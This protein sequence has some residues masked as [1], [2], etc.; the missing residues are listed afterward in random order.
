MTMENEMDV[1]AGW[2][3]DGTGT[4]TTR[5]WDGGKWT[6]K[7][8]PPASAPRVSASVASATPS[9]AEQRASKKAA[10]VARSASKLM[11]RQGRRHLRVVKKQNRH[12]AQDHAAWVAKVE[13]LQGMLQKAQHFQ[14]GS[15]SEI[16]LK[17][18]ELQYSSIPGSLI[19]D[20]AGQRSFV[21]GHQ[22]VSIPIGKIG[23]R[24][25][26]YY[27]GKTKGH[28]VQAPPV[29]TVIDRGRIIITN[30][31]VVF[32]GITQTRE[33]LFSKLVAYEHLD[34]GDTVISVSNRQ[35]PT[36]LHYAASVSNEFQFALVLAIASF[37]IETAA[38][39][40]ELA[41]RLNVEK[42]SEPRLAI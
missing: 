34:V 28:P 37:R 40:Q 29:A 16:L 3:D 18:K 12:F 42:A 17:T 8:A 20:R 4:A 33:S 38:L 39:A 21:A 30:Q 5:W 27:A 6:D 36:R 26:R 24:S 13:D 10:R 7:A 19:E 35:K 1:L 25:V 23:G 11:Q 9:A 22:G 32:Q 41:T 2:Y 14:G 15:S 31:R